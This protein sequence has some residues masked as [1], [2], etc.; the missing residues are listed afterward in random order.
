MR[1]MVSQEVVVC[2]VCHDKSASYACGKCGKD[3]CYECFGKQ[4]IRYTHGI[5]S[6]GSGDGYYC[7]DCNAALIAKPTVLFSAYRTMA[8]LKAEAEAWGTDFW[9]RADAAEAEIKR[10]ASR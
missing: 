5:Y 9:K 4:G 6:S 10:L 3:F 1:K 2:D 7:L 8:A